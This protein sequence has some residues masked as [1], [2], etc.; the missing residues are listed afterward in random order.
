MALILI[1]ADLVAN[2]TSSRSSTPLKATSSQLWKIE[3][4]RSEQWMSYPALIMLCRR[5]L[6]RGEEFRD[7]GQLTRKEAEMVR[8]ELE[9]NI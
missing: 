5:I 1:S 8:E 4:L 9:R 2:S 6:Q 7:I 3:D